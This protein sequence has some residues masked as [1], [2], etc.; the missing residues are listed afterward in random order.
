MLFDSRNVLL[1]H[2]NFPVSAAG[3]R[4]EH[5]VGHLR[6]AARDPEF[7]R[8][9]RA[10][11]EDDKIVA[12]PRLRDD[13][14]G[15]CFRDCRQ[16]EANLT[17]SIVHTERCEQREVMIDCVDEPDLRGDELVITQSAERLAANSVVGDP[18]LG[19]GK[20]GKNC[21]AIRAR[22]VEAVIKFRFA[23]AKVGR[24]ET[25]RAQR[26]SIKPGMAGGNSTSRG[27]DERDLCAGKAFVARRS[28]EP[29]GSVTDPF[30]LD[31]KDVQPAPIAPSACSS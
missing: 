9:R 4:F 21:R 31:Q 29:S 22:K 7:L 17:R 15:F 13:L 30:E 24:V 2:R 8:A 16:F 25:V 1:L 23:T 3:R 20:H 14:C 6:P 11:V 10:R 28:L 27:G 26:K 19:A 5:P 18:P 12:Q